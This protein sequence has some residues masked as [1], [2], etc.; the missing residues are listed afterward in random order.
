MLQHQLLRKQEGAQ[1]KNP[2]LILAFCGKK[3]VTMI[4]KSISSIIL[5]C[6]NLWIFWRKKKNNLHLHVFIDKS[7][8]ARFSPWQTGC[9]KAREFDIDKIQ[10]AD[11][12]RS[13][14]FSQNILILVF[15]KKKA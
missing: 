2:H 11:P 9:R 8:F 15:C 1:Q 4:N 7:K 14:I 3:P 12:T 13:Y 10:Y 6:L 5:K